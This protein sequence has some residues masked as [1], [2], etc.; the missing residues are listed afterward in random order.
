MRR[1]GIVIPFRKAPEPPP[2]GRGWVVAMVLAGAVVLGVA[3]LLG[4]CAHTAAGDGCTATPRPKPYACMEH[5]GEKKCGWLIDDYCLQ[6]YY[7]PSCEAEW[8]PH[9]VEC[10]HPEGA[11]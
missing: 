8:E 7:R 2:R 9:G 4:G 3:V 11:Q 5:Q 1:A 6:N 10:Y